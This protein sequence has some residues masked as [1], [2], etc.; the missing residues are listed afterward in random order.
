MKKKILLPLLMATCLT[1][2]GSKTEPQVSKI[3]H[4]AIYCDSHNGSFIGSEYDYCGCKNYRSMKSDLD[5]KNIIS[6]D[7]ENVATS[8]TTHI[9]YVVVYTD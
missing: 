3:Q 5:G 2:C 6:I 8:N 4:Y 1:A 9:H 7:C